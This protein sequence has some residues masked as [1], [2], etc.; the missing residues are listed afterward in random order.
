MATRDEGAP[1]DATGDARWRERAVERSLRTARARAVSRSDRF[2]AAANELLGE[3]ERTDFTV[4]E[5]VER[6]KMSLRSFYQHFGSKDE[7]LIALFEE[8]IRGYIA[9]LR[10]IVQTHV[11]AVEQ[12][13]AF[14][15]GLYGT[16]EG[17]LLP[18]SRA[19]TLYHLQL[20][21]SHPAEFANALAPQIELL[22]EILDAGI[23]TGQFRDDVAPRQLAILLNHTMVSALHMRVLGIHTTVAGVSA[24]DLWA[25]CYGGV[26]PPASAGAL[27]APRRRV[28]VARR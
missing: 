22:M 2:I 15:T 11:D 20:A 23:A 25:F 28:R 12:L 21:D 27:V 26:A 18:G 16:V 9:H 6:S 3:T 13:R 10:G 4:Q 1:E 7:L 14:V 17:K 19:L 24:E 8:A 5:I